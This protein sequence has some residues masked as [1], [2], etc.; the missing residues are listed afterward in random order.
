MSECPATCRVVQARP[1][2]SRLRERLVALTAAQ[3]P[4][5]KDRLLARLTSFLADS[6]GYHFPI[7]H[8]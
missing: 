3:V 2:T 1:C 5:Q 6:A 8:G 7:R 4:R